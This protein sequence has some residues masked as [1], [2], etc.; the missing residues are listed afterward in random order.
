[1]RQLTVKQKKVLTQ[2]LKDNPEVNCY[3]DLPHAIIETLEKIND[4]EILW[5]ECDR[6][7]SDYH[8]RY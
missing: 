8:C 2:A 1:M 4:T 5:S 6:F 3:D 7:I